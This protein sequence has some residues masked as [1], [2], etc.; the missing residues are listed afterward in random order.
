MHLVVN[1]ANETITNGTSQSNVVGNTGISLKLNKAL[2]ISKPKNFLFNEEYYKYAIEIKINGQ[3]WV[4][5]RRFSEIRDEHERMMKKCP[6]L[7][8]ES[9]PA[10]SP[11]NKNDTF[12]MERQQKLEQYLRNFIL[13]SL[14]DSL[15]EFSAT[16]RAVDSNVRPTTSQAASAQPARL[17]KEVFCERLPFFQE[18]T[19]DKLN[20]QKLN[21]KSTADDM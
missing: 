16:H 2:L 18:S 14:G 10:R 7:K 4:I 11:F 6:A 20:V 21:W 13:V 9:F 19:E 12:Q 3:Y 5:F 8:K 17:T 1:L 15:Y